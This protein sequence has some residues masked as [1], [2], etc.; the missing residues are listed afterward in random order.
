M[1]S[2][3][4]AHGSPQAGKQSWEISEKS[5]G[6]GEESGKREG[7]PHWWGQIPSGGQQS[8]PV[9]PMLR[10]RGQC[11][12]WAQQ[13]GKQ[14][15]SWDLLGPS[16]CP[17][18]HL[19]PVTERKKRLKSHPTWWSKCQGGGVV[20]F[21]Y[22]E[23]S[24]AV[25][26]AKHSGMMRGRLVIYLLYGF[27]SWMPLPFIFLMLLPDFVIFVIAVCE[28]FFIIKLLYSISHIFCWCLSMRH[29]KTVEPNPKI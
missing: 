12:S 11:L 20:S 16:S 6:R 15:L 10:E 7:K 19:L 25:H 13:G 3:P 24:G 9:F 4:P 21:I 26:N 27:F 17:E 18:G 2:H 28:W 1:V 23:W 29:V 5:L 8:L 22:R 14:G